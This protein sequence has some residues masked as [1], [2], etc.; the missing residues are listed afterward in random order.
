MEFSQIIYIALARWDGQYTSTAFSIAKELSNQEKTVY[1]IE[2]PLTLKDVFINIHKKEIT[3]RLLALFLGINNTTNIKDNLIAVIPL[4]VFPINWMPKGKLYNL[5]T[6]F[7]NIL[8]AKSIQKIIKKEKLKDYIIY[9]SF[10]PFY[11]FTSKSNPAK[12][13]IYQS[14]DDISQSDYIKKHGTYLEKKYAQSSDLVFV[15]SSHLKRKLTEYNKNTHLVANAANIKMFNKTL[16]QDENE[17]NL[18]AS[19]EK[20]KVII[21]YVGNIC[22]RINY[23]LLLKIVE[24]YPEYLLLM[25]GPINARN[26]EIQRLKK[27]NNTCFTGSK[28]PTELI[29]YLKKMDCAIIPFLKNELTK[30]IYP[31]KINEY[32]AAGLPVITTNFSEDIKSFKDVIYLCD[33]EEDFIIQIQKSIKENSL[34][35]TKKR[36]EFVSSN[37][38]TNRTLQILDIIKS[39]SS[40]ER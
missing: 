37:N 30:S 34:D 38:W 5:F 33:N 36:I 26:P 10:N 31:L 18:E 17:V 2:N 12:L 7:N 39:Q 13:S 29:P 4:S 8:F 24:E 21:G 22:H 23:Q 11:T 3:K 27:Y 9:N 28:K 40:Y 25:V 14:V 1:Y 16:K 32:L 15:T 6:K 20:Y 19:F 35:M